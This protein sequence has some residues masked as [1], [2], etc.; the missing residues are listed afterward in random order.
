MTHSTLDPAP[1]AGPRPAGRS[2]L[3]I[4][5][6]LAGTTAALAL[7]DAGLR[8]TLVEGRPRLGGLAFSFHRSSPAGVLSVDNGQHVYL[9]CCTAYQWFLER[10]ESGRTHPL[11]EPLVGRAAPQVHMLAVVDADYA[12]LRAP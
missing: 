10:G 7:A 6:G 8:V 2:A 9:R 1:P 3:V 11:Q 12:R 4:G 5:G